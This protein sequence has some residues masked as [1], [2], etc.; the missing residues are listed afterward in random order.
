MF[1]LAEGQLVEAPVLAHCDPQLPFPLTGDT[2]AY[3]F[4]AVISHVYPDGSEWPIDY[5]S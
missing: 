1:V 4:G 5:A 2:S 3:K